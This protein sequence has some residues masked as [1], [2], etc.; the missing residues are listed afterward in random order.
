MVRVVDLTDLLQRGAGEDVVVALVRSLLEVPHVS[1]EPVVVVGG[2]EVDALVFI[3]HE[4]AA[5]DQER[6][7]LRPGERRFHRVPREEK[8]PPI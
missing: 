8:A 2:E 6:N 3:L 4:E 5:A 7:L 1:G